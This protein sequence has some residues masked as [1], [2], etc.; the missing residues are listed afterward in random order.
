MSIT[1]LLEKCSPKKK[2]KPNQGSERMLKN[3]SENVENVKCSGCA[4]SC[5]FQY[6]YMSNLRVT[7]FTEHP[8]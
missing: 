3:Y 5:L 2:K 6:L 1:E 8:L 7:S 4:V